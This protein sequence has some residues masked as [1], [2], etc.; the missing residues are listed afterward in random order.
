MKPVDICWSGD[1]HALFPRNEL[2]KI[3][4]SHVSIYLMRNLLELMIVVVTALRASAPSLMTI[5]DY[6]GAR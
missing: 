3:I 2:P 6:G 5:T 1:A 4:A